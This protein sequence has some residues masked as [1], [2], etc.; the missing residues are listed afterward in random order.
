MF[1]RL[2]RF[3]KDTGRF[4]PS[5]GATPDTQPD[6]Q[7]TGGHSGVTAGAPRGDFTEADLTA[8]QAVGAWV[9]RNGGKPDLFS[10]VPYW[11]DPAWRPD[12]EVD[13][14]GSRQRARLPGDGVAAGMRPA[15]TRE[16][17]RDRNPTE[18]AKYVGIDA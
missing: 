3:I 6:A 11:S 4:N 1:R 12:V 15:L 14:D 8:L 5:A 18:Y 9:P 16:E 10:Y 17:L 2:K 13:I 7:T